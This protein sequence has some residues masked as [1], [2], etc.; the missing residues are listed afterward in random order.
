MVGDAFVEFHNANSI[1]QKVVFDTYAVR[2]VLSRG[3]M[4]GV[5]ETYM[6]AEQATQYAVEL[7]QNGDGRMYHAAGERTTNNTG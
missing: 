7:E 3:A 5:C 1:Q 2:H 6:S 4:R